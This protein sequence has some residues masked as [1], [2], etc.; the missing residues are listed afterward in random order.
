LL[1]KDYSNAQEKALMMPTRN[2]M[3][4]IGLQALCVSCLCDIPQH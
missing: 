4:Y 3:I 1:E 2:H